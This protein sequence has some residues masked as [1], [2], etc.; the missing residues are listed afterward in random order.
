[1]SFDTFDFNGELFAS[2][3]VGLRYKTPIGPIRFDVARPVDDSSYQFHFSIGQV[4]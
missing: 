3:G 1:M 2:Y 4:F